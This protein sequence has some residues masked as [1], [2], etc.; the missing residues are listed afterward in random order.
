LAENGN[1]LEYGWTP[2]FGQNPDAGIAGPPG[3]GGV[4]AFGAPPA[5]GPAPAPPRAM[6]TAVRPPPI[7]QA[8]PVP[9]RPASPMTYAGYG[10]FGADAP[11][12]P[13]PPPATPLENGHTLG[14]AILASGVGG[15]VGAKYGGL[16]GG[17]AGVLYGGALTNLIRAAR[18]VVRGTP[19]ADKEAAISATWAVISAG[20]ATYIW[21]KSPGMKM[22]SARNPD[23]EDDEGGEDEPDED[24]EPEPEPDEGDED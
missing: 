21:V 15:A 11:P 20:I 13:A 12:A 23:D 3:F 14:L 6:P 7:A 9:L 5:L 19:E 10:G 16:F 4:P 8:D 18:S 24:P 22:R 1:G 2:L 17:A